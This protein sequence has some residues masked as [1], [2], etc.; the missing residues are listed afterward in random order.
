MDA[1]ADEGVCRLLRVGRTVSDLPRAMAF[2]RDALGFAAIGE[3]C[4]ADPAAARLLGGAACMRR[5]GMSLGADEIE[6]IAFDPPGH[7]YPPDSTAADL[8]F[9]HIA[10]V[11]S[12]IDAAYQR[13]QGHGS[14]AITTDGPQRL[15]PAAGGVSAFKFRDPDGHPVELIEFPLGTGAPKWRG[16]GA[17]RITMGC[18]H[19][20]ISVADV[21]RSVTFYTRLLGLREASRRFNRSVEQDRLDGLHEVAVDVI[22]LQT[23][24]VATPHLELLAYRSPRGRAAQEPLRPDH[25]ACDRLVF[26][27]A[28]LNA[29]IKPIERAGR[30]SGARGCATISDAYADGSRAALVRDPDGH[31]LMLCE[32][33]T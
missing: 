14:G 15:P 27:V 18:D 24:E 16:Q 12:D 32:A 13:L 6:L 5:V 10:V 17:S 3:I 23:G 11:A 7:V 2:Y 26:E 4:D 20:A 22:A 33:T 25:I 31:L 1:R 29:L 28:N 30:T 19:S 8:W 21:E 9:Q